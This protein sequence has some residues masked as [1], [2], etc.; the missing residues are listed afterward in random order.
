MSPP[1]KPTFRRILPITTQVRSLCRRLTVGSANGPY[2]SSCG[3][4]RHCRGARQPPKSEAPS[5]FSSVGAD[6]KVVQ[7]II[8][9]RARTSTTQVCVCVC[10][11]VVRLLSLFSASI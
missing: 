6:K 8:S 4:T 9:E 1:P 2:S 3:R 10:V 7:N 5:S 11:C